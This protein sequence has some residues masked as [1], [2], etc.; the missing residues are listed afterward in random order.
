[1]CSSRAGSLWVATWYLRRDDEEYRS[2][3]R[4]LLVYQAKGRS[5]ILIAASAPVPYLGDECR[6][7]SPSPIL[8]TKLHRLGESI[9]GAVARAGDPVLRVVVDD[10][11]LATP[12]ITA[13][14]DI[15]WQ[16]GGYQLMNS[17]VSG[18]SWTWAI[19]DQPGYQVEM[20]DSPLI[21]VYSGGPTDTRVT[22]WYATPTG[23]QRA[24]AFP[25]PGLGEGVDVTP[26]G[27]AGSELKSLLVANERRMLVASGEAGCA[28]ALELRRP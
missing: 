4:S 22:L 7:C 9:V 16:S 12:E 23:L 27:A 11:L 14:K 3:V 18:W 17:F 5:E 26:D 28:E 21:R 13:P 8:T 15:W 20:R 25:L 2:I 10:R 19:A 24:A 6:G 1:M